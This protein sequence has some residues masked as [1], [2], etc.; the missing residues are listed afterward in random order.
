M[1]NLVNSVK[2]SAQELGKVSTVA[3]CGMLIA[4][5]VILRFFTINVTLILRVG[6]AF[7]PVAAASMLFGPL[8]GGIVGALGDVITYF[9]NPTGPYF[10]GFTISGYVSGFLY[11]LIL[12]KRP[13]GFFRALSAKA[14]VTVVISFVLNPIWLA[15]FYG[16]AFLAVLAARIVPQL[17]LLPV[18]VAMLFIMLK[19]L[20]K[21]PV[22]LPDRKF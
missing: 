1:K 3:M 19:I 8:T 18:D 17:A 11:G 15:I 12:Y 13:V 7:L 6:F 9:V 16:K 21:M 14:A 10:P 20:D 4:L 22:R 5:Q 2:L